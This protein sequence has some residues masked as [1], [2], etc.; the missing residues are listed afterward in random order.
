MRGA[1]VYEVIFRVVVEPASLVLLVVV[2]ASPEEKTGKNVAPN[3]Q[4]DQKS[5]NLVAGLQ[6][7]VGS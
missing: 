4:N 1:E 3:V 5:N 7:C 2:V 6:F